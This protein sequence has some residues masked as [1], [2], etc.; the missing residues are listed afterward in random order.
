MAHDGP[1]LAG[2]RAAAKSMKTGHDRWTWAA[3]A[4]SLGT[5]WDTLTAAVSDLSWD[6]ASGLPRYRRAYAV[7]RRLAV[8]PPQTYPEDRDLA[9]VAYYLR[10]HVASPIIKS[11]C[12]RVLKAER[13][14]VLWQWHVKAEGHVHGIDIFW[15]SSPAPPRKARAS[16]NGWISPT[17]PPTSI[18]RG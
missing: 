14:V 15:P 18:S 8:S 17:T 7:A 11:D 1:G 16:R 13:K 4:V 6:L 10:A 5:R 9:D 12:T 2:G 3:S